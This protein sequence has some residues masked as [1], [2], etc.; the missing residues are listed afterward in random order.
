MN[1]NDFETKEN[2]ILSWIKRSARETLA[3]WLV[4]ESTG[5]RRHHRKKAALIQL[6][7]PRWRVI[8][9]KANEEGIVKKQNKTKKKQVIYVLQGF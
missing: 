4:G 5:N 7:L 3:K 8:L 2:N 6:Q 1:V 9:L